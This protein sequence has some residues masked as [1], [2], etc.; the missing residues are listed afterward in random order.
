[1]PDIIEK[2]L[3]FK[4]LPHFENNIKLLFI[5]LEKW[6]KIFALINMVI[7]ELLYRLDKNKYL[8]YISIY[9]KFGI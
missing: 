9:S 8:F 4:K 5:N 6:N 7:F 1:M 3:K 2:K